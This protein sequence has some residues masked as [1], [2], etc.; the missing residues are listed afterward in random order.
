MSNM[1]KKNLPPYALES[2]CQENRITSS[3]ILT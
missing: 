3:D 1:R 2:Y